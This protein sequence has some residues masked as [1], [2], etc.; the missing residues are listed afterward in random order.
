MKKNYVILVA[1]ELPRSYLAA[2]SDEDDGLPAN[3]PERTGDVERALIFSDFV[4]ARSALRA[5][6][7]R[8][9]AHQ[10]HLDLIDAITE[11]I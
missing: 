11:A 5:A 9:P 2:E 7:R 4:T 3:G 6:V 1:P 10:F 8:Y